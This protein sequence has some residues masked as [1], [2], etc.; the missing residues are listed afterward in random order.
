MNNNQNNNNDHNK[1]N[2]SDNHG[3]NILE[4]IICGIKFKTPI[5]TASGTF[6]YGLE[7]I[8]FMDLNL[9]G[10]ISIKGISLEPVEGNPMPR[11]VETAS[12]LLNAIGLQ[13]VG[14]KSFIA[15]KLPILKSFDTNIIV[16]FWGKS[17]DEYLKVAEILDDTDGVDMLE[18]NISCP[19]IKDG[20][21][22]FS[23]TPIA[24]SEIVSKVR[25]VVRNK[26][27][28][29]KL[30]PNVT[31]IKEYLKVVEVE[32]ADSVSL[33]NTLI[34]MAIDIHKFK[35]VLANKTGGLSGPAI[36]PVALRM[37]YEAF[38]TVKIPIIG[39]G[40]IMT[41]NDAAEFILAGADIVQVGTAN[42]TDPSAAINISNEL[43]DY[44]NSK[45]FKSI[46][47]FR[48]KAVI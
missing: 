24:T 11:I 43:R 7:F 23:S 30:S 12:G 5:I 46:D 28:I 34:G 33:I 20:G 25:K 6:G 17:I 37:V 9:L 13:N 21:I 48:G 38:S 1:N 45:S 31:D 22:S 47:D 39:M 42:F 14:V 2:N 18:M 16:N 8:R 27:L 29:V 4:K 15:E 40:G 32:G 41:G 36:K 19:N 44:M 26:P 10:G 35:P 3:I